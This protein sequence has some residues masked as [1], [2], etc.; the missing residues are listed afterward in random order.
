MICPMC[1]QEMDDV[2]TRFICPKCGYDSCF[3]CESK[4]TPDDYR[5]EDEDRDM[6]K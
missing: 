5:Y 3:G 4:S 2:S 6:N 1:G